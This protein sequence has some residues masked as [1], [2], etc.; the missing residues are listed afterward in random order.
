MTA[1]DSADGVLEDLS[2]P[3]PTVAW[4]M[5]NVVLGGCGL[6]H[7]GANLQGFENLKV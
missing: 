4:K 7:A 2:A 6:T 3:G 1:K 5:A